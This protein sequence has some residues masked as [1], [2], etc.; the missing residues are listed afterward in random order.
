MGRRG[1]SQ[2]TLILSVPVAVTRKLCGASLGIESSVRVETMSLQSHSSEL[3]LRSG[4]KDCTMNSYSLGL[5]GLKG[6]RGSCLQSSIRHT[7]THT[8]TVCVLSLQAYRHGAQL[9]DGKLAVA[10]I[11]LMHER[12]LSGALCVCSWMV[13]GKKKKIIHCHTEDEVCRKKLP[14]P[15]LLINGNLGRRFM[16]P[17]GALRGLASLRSS[18]FSASTHVLKKQTNSLI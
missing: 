4:L 2:A 7:R 15:V 5:R 9:R 16:H 12:K 13:N 11:L 1:G 10:V 17:E 14:L 8:I 18:S 6:L 3:T